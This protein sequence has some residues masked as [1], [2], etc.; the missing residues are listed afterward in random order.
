MKFRIKLNE[1]IITNYISFK[2]CCKMF[3]KF[4][5][6]YH[7]DLIESLPRIVDE[8]GVQSD[9]FIAYE[10]N[11]D[12]IK[13]VLKS[14]NRRYAIIDEIVCVQ[15]FSYEDENFVSSLILDCSEEVFE[16]EEMEEIED[17]YEVEEIEDDFEENDEDTLKEFC[18]IKEESFDFSIEGLMQ[19][20]VANDELLETMKVDKDSHSRLI[21]LVMKAYTYLINPLPYD[22]VAIDVK[23]GHWEECIKYAE[24]HDLEKPCLT[25]NR[26][27]VEFFKQ[28]F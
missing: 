22:E 21:D 16:I 5:E 15:T 17:F 10:E 11:M 14:Y 6:W 19:R 2:K 8:F 20:I 27:Y 24:M 25:L 23:K 3:L 9:L 18:G 26:E 13:N 28:I 7:T 12:R 4:I 1:N